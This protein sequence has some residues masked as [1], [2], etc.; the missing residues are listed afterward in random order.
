MMLARRTLIVWS[1]AAALLAGC[2][3]LHTGERRLQGRFSLRVTDEAGRRDAQQGRFELLDAPSLRRL[4]LLTPLSGVLAR[5]EAAPGKARLY[6]GSGDA[7]VRAGSAEDLTLSI[8]G[9]PVPVTT[10]SELLFAPAP[11]QIPDELTVDGWLVRI[12]SRFPAG[13]PRQV[14]LNKTSP[15]PGLADITLTIVVEESAIGQ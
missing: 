4:D 14:R 7:V 6:R 9:F 13:A 12:L 3:T 10:L 11:A 5:I 15:A 8:I 2:Q 1:A